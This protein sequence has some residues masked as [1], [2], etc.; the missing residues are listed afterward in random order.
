[1]RVARHHRPHAAIAPHVRRDADTSEEDLHDRGRR[2]DLDARADQRARHAVEAT[3]ELYVVIDVDLSFLPFGLL[4]AAT[5]ERLQRG[6]IELLERRPPAAFEL[7]EG[8][9]V[10]PLEQLA[11]GLV[12]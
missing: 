2:A 11:D 10:E 3:F 7:L 5:G 4:V 8:P 12:E 9:G 1:M 6:P